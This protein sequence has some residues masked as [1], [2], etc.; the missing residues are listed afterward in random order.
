MD[1]FQDCQDLSRFLDIF[2]EILL[3]G[4]CG[5]IW[6]STVKWIKSSNLVR[7]FWKFKLLLDQD[8]EIIDFWQ[9]LIS[10]E[11]F[12]PGHWCW[13]QRFESVEIFST[14]ETYS[15]PVSRW[16]PPGFKIY[17]LKFGIDHNA[18]S[19][20]TWLPSKWFI[21]EFVQS[22]SKVPECEHLPLGMLRGEEAFKVSM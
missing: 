15:L 12:R 3:I 14:V 19:D 20:Q 13:D 6:P 16:R 1:T 9:I 17:F 22:F 2:W 21:D 18:A 11:T 10:I 5:S 8:R 7:D 4:I